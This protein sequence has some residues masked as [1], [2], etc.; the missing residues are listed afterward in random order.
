MT[1]IYKLIFIFVFAKINP[2]SKNATGTRQTL[3]YVISTKIILV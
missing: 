1:D 3:I 2:V